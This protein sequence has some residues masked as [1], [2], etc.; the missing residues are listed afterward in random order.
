MVPLGRT[1]GQLVLLRRLTAALADVMVPDD[2]AR[3]TLG[4]VVQIDRVVRAGLSTSERAGRELS[5][6]ST[7]DDAVTP[8][9]RPVVP[10]RGRGRRT[11][12]GVCAHRGAG[13]ARL[14]RGAGGPL[15][16][17]ARPPDR[18]G[19]PV[20][21]GAAVA[22]RRPRDRRPAALLR[23]AAAFDDELQAFLAAVAALVAQAMKRALAF[24]V[25][26]T[27]SELLSAA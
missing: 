9:R 19:H 18:P 1:A 16:A 15:P 4:H 21:G 11:A 5:F 14:H 12:R 13:A 10:D 3:V 2:V 7:D 20:V 25:Q 23:C 24:R 8:D 27:T 17:P 22:G 6:V 26:Q